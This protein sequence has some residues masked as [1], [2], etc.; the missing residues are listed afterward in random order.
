MSAKVGM[1][2]DGTVTAIQGNWLIDTGYYSMTTQSQIAVGCGEV[3]I[4]VKCPNWDF[5][6]SHRLYEPE[7]LGDRKGLWWPGA[8]VL[9]DSVPESGHGKGQ[10]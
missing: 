6:T 4:M 7:C 8:E 3:Q 1:K 10:C 9:S 5:K 2:K